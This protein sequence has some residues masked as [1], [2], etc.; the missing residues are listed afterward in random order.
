MGL[1]RFV[2]H[3]SVHQPVNDK[4]PGLGLG[5]YGQWFTRHETWAEKAKPWVTYLTRSSYMLQQGK[6]VADVAYFYGEDSNVTALFGNK[7]PD[8]PAG[9]NFD[10]INGDGFCT[11]C[12]WKEAGSPR[13]AA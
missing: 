3:T 6:F 8:V 2:I 7:A 1:N 12:R 13:P 4:I 10:Y 9:D 5:P 11:A